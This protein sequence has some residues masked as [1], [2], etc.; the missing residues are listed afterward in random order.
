[1]ASLA[2]RW[3][4]SNWFLPAMRET[5]HPVPRLILRL[6]LRLMPMLALP[7]MGWPQ[8]ESSESEWRCRAH[9]Y[10]PASMLVLAWLL[11]LPRRWLSGFFHQ[12]RRLPDSWSRPTTDSLPFATGPLGKGLTGT[13][14]TIGGRGT[15]NAKTGFDP[16]GSGF[17]A[18]PFAPGVFEG[19]VVAVPGPACG[20]KL[21]GTAGGG[22]VD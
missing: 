6:I 21:E 8:E 15:R 11:A 1:M 5:M 3:K 17:L 12:S 20:D 14:S 7:A 16:R 13:A 9:S 22:V 18:V 10:S 19:V 2:R 4:V